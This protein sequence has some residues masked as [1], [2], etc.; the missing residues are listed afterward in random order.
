MAE[1]P[2]LTEAY[3]VIILL[4]PGFLTFRLFTWRASYEFV[5]SNLQI[6][7]W[8]LISSV[9]V[10]VPFAALWQF[11][12]ITDLENQV[13]QYD[14]I[15]SYFILATVIGIG[16][17]ELVRRKWRK[18]VSSGSVWANFAFVNSGDWVDVYT[19][20]GNVYRGW[21]KQMST[22]ET[23]QRELEL[24]EPELLIEDGKKWKSIGD[25]MIFT[26]KDIARIV[27]V[28]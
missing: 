9:I 15:G 18:N 13:L 4:A 21:I 2:S 1:I 16:T 19:I 12:S 24:R 7:L 14:V 10:F 11:K 20:E 8:S 25:S 27:L 22:F 3:T 6:T 28:K 23:H 17:G 5:F 26:E